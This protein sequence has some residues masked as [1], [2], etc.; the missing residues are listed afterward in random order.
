M[1][2]Y[3]QVV[4][5]LARDTQGD[6]KLLLIAARDL[7]EN[8]KLRLANPKP[9]P[10][11]ND[12]EQPLDL[13]ESIELRCIDAIGSIDGDSLCDIADLLIGEGDPDVQALRHQIG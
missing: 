1:T 13:A 7:I 4:E 6:E 11:S 3:E 12:N 9:L 5:T 8:V 10:I 2:P